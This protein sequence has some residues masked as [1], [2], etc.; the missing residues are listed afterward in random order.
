M[1]WCRRS[2]CFHD[3]AHD[4]G[5]ALHVFFPKLGAQGERE[6]FLA[7][8]FGDRRLHRSSIS[9]REGPLAVDGDG[10]VNSRG[11]A[12]FTERAHELFPLR[13]PDHEEVPGR[14]RPRGFH[15]EGEAAV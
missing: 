2:G 6:D 9:G 15:G 3:P 14:N 7:D 8:P 13:G 5:D 10:V 12:F 1:F 11:D 4:Q